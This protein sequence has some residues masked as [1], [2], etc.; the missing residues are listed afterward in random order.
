MAQRERG[1]TSS[2]FPASHPCVGTALP[3]GSSLHILKPKV[4][5]VGGIRAHQEEQEDAGSVL[6]HFLCTDEDHIY[7]HAGATKYELCNFG[8]ST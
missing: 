1:D 2:P 8:E 7:M 5:D 3:L 6:W 4:E